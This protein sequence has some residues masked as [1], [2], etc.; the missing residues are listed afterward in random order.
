LIHFYK[1]IFSPHPYE[2]TLLRNK[3]GWSPFFVLFYQQTL[4]KPEVL[5]IS[6]PHH[7]AL[8]TASQVLDSTTPDHH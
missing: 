8:L 3:T 6:H 4:D 5:G 2:S 7:P 1:R